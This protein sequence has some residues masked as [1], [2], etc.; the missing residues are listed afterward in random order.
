MNDG[1]MK[2]WLRARAVCQL[3]YSTSYHVLFQ[4]IHI[5][6]CSSIGTG[7]TRPFQRDGGAEELHGDPTVD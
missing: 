2:I 5:A 1:K 4:S 6:G 7:A 3:C